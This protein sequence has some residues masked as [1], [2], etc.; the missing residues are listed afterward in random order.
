MSTDD[1]GNAPQNFS[2]PPLSALGTNDS[3][4]ST[5]PIIALALVVVI[6]T[7]VI[8]LLIYRRYHLQVKKV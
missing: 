7:A 8:S 3:L 2:M 4:L 5:K 6:S 1:S